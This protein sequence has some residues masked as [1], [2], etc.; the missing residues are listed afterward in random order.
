MNVLFICNKSP[1]PPKEGG[2][3]AM[4]NLIQGLLRKKY[5][6]KVLS[7]STPKL[8]I[9]SKDICDDFAKETSFETHFIDTSTTIKGAFINIFSHLPYHISRFIDP[10]FSEKIK[11]ILVHDKFD[12]IQLESLYVTPYIDVIRKYSSAKIILRAH[13]I[14]HVIWERIGLNEKNIFRKLYIKK[15]AERLKKYELNIINKV[16]GICA[17]TPA[18]AT[19]FNMNKCTAPLSVI[20]FGIDDKEQNEHINNREIPS[21]FFLGTLNWLPN[22]EGLMWFIEHVWPTITEKKPH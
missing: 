18:D 22:T 3:I 9:N 15:Q 17:I 14:E 11:T 12:I 19:Y 7:I 8:P 6:V 13:N 20:P 10:C 21:V 2:S 5:K 16:D 1:Y 4:F